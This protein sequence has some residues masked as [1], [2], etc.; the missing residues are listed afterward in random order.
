MGA[1]RVYFVESR[2]PEVLADETGTAWLPTFFARH[3]RLV[4]SSRARE[5]LADF[6]AFLPRIYKVTP[7]EFRRALTEQAEGS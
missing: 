5:V 6:D 7:N 2:D 4:D 3:A 1:D